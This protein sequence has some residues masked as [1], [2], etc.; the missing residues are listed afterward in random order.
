[1]A[2]NSAN[3]HPTRGV[4][5]KGISSMKDV[6]E[7]VEFWVDEL[8]CLRGLEL[9][10]PQIQMQQGHPHPVAWQWPSFSSHSGG[11]LLWKCTKAVT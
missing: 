5:T 1:M 2:R 7:V 3:G 8:D 6:V 10:S 9:V 11:A 4:P